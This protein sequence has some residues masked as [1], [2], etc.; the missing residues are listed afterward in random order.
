MTELLA[1]A[2]NMEAL[3]AAIV[4]GADAV[5]VGGKQFS[6][7]AFADNFSDEEL[8]EAIRLAHFHGKKL[9]LAVN[10]L[11]ADSE[12]P[13]ALEYVAAFYQQ[14]VDAVIVQDMGL[15]RL[16]RENMPDLPVHASTQ[17]T[18]TGISAA[19]F[20][21]AQGVRRAIVARELSLAEIKAIGETAEL[22]LE[23]FVHGALCICYSGQCLMSSMIGGRSGNR[24]RCAQPC[25]LPYTLCDV[26]GDPLPIKEQGVHL[27]SPRDLHGYW[28]IEDLHGL[29]IAAWKIEGRMKKPEYVATV[30]RIYGEHLRLLDAQ[31]IIYQDEE[32]QRQ[33]LQMFNRDYCR[34]YWLGD[35]GASLMSYKRPNNRGVFLGR[36]MRRTNKDIMMKLERPLALGD[37]LE[38][39]VSSGGRYGCEVEVIYRGGDSVDEAL[40]GEVVLLPAAAGK[41]GDR[42]FKTYDHKLTEQARQS[43]AALP[44]TPLHFIINAQAGRALKVSAHDEDGFQAE[45]VSAY[46]VTKALS[47]VTDWQNVRAQLSRLGGSGYSFGSLDGTLEDGIMLPASVLNACRRELVEK[48]MEIRHRPYMRGKPQLPHPLIKPAPA[49]PAKAIRVAAL[50]DD[51]ELAPRLLKAGVGEVYFGTEGFYPGLMPDAVDWPALIVACDRAG[52]RLTACLPHIIKPLEEE[53]WAKRIAAW[54]DMG[55]SALRVNNAGQIALAQAAGWQGAL[56]GGPGL[57]VFNSY[58]YRFYSEQ[59]LQRITLSPELHLA[60]LTAL[61]ADGAEKELMAQGALPLMVSEHCALGALYGGHDKENRC[62]EP[63]RNMAGYS[64][65]DE[66]GFLFPCRSDA[67]CRM[68]I[69]N[70]RELCLLEE[71]PALR[72]AGIG[73]LC[74]D[75]RLYQRPMAIRLAELYCLAL[76]DEWAFADAK[77]KLSQVMRE[78][79]KGHLHRGV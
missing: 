74:L 79:T 48:L 52:G 70:A 16:I 7:R 25:R 8:A 47:S 33:L 23:V 20:L 32:E 67:A 72:G 11:L 73:C 44:L 69:F 9:Y 50:T 24:G 34:G 10:T 58:S 63:C 38:I 75:L 61:A 68:H 26:K 53:A 59:G 41:E 22:E 66:K 39:W 55:L 17:M 35:P 27:L 54:Q 3:K 60:R 28:R 29:N 2:G 12:L 57:N 51:A 31:R 71:I 5:Y 37:G 65:S 40:P 46:V 18:I 21:A 13:R 64:L 6:A 43:Y 1:P 14:G 76:G 15:L 49:Q 4:N 62:S 36:I 78:Y 30:C 42:V 77:A 56:L 45:T 19:R